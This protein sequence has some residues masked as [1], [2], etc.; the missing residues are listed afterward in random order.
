M[1]RCSQYLDVWA[2]TKYGNDALEWCNCF[3]VTV[4]KDVQL[5]EIG[6]QILYTNMS[7]IKFKKM[8]FVKF[9]SVSSVQVHRVIIPE[10]TSDSEKV[11]MSVAYFLLPDRDCLVQCLDGSD[12]YEPIKSIDSLNTRLAG[13]RVW[14]KKTSTTVYEG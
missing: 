14:E 1:S 8:I 11:R 2:Q 5:S 13:E 10:A 6:R 3:I 12:K 9:R 7:Y 4:L